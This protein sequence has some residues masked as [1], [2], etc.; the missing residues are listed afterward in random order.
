MAQPTGQ[1]EG[2]NP[3]GIMSFWSPNFA[4]P[5]MLW[6]F[7]F[8]RIQWGMVPKHNFNSKN[9]CYAAKLTTAQVAALPVGVDIETIDWRRN[10]H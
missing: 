8:Y 10:R 6:N 4:E 7:W 3:L 1:S 5:I 2:T 9:F